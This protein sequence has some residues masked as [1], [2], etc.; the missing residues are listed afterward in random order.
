MTSTSIDVIYTHPRG[1]GRGSGWAPLVRMAVLAA[2]C[3]GGRLIEY[4]R[5]DGYGRTQ[6]YRGAV[7]RP[8][9][10]AR[11]CLVIAP[12][13][14]HLHAATELGVWN[15]RYSSVVGWVI[16]SFWHDRVPRIARRTRTFDHIYVADD[17][18]VAPWADQARAPVSALPWGADTLGIV[19]AR[20]TVDIQRLGRQPSQ[21]DDDEA[22]REAAALR[23]LTY[24]GRPP[25][26]E[27]ELDG[28]K[29]VEEAAARAK[30]VLA[31]SNLV[32]PASHT[33]PTREYLTGRWTDSLAAGAVVAGV[34]PKTA[35][36]RE[37]LWP[38]AC[39][40]LSSV[41]RATGLAEIASAIGAWDESV[42]ERNR[43]QAR[44]R[45]D[46]RH[47]FKVLADGLGIHAPTL[48]SQ[49]RALA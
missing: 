27:S 48:E 11:S 35:T 26:G 10:G 30:Y 3:L 6:I 29:A 18:D 24:A 38:G 9:S 12:E 33:H 31:F 43:A 34:A 21:W 1:S 2:E 15:S 46:W 13:P 20:K 14:T 23:G 25:F 47:R 22:N 19:P 41:D 39:L 5:P 28:Q 45:L 44:R 8:R 36:A 37:L 4:D 16:D 17:D 49:L 32:S 7:S 40:E 42:A